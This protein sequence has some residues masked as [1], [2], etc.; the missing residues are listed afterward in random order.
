MV[1]CAWHSWFNR[2]P[3]FVVVGGPAGPPFLFPRSHPEAGTDRPS[4]AVAAQTAAVTGYASG[5]NT[6][7]RWGRSARGLSPRSCIQSAAAFCT[8]GKSARSRL[9]L[10]LQGLEHGERDLQL[11]LQA[12]ALNPF[13]QVA[14]EFP[15][16][17]HVA[18]QPLIDR[19]LSERP[20]V[21]HVRDRFQAAQELVRCAVRHW[22][23]FSSIEIRSQPSVNAL[24]RS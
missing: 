3:S 19:R 17:V 7:G 5:A 24:Q 18:E 20:G 16:P 9:S 1:L 6:R 21:Q 23:S 10:R 4:G 14:E 15:K 13:V 12:L 2:T 8:S 22:I 11:I